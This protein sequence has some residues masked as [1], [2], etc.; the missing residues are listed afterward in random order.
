MFPGANRSGFIRWSIAVGPRELYVS[1]VSSDR[2]GVPCVFNAPAVIA[3]GQLPGD[4]MPPSISAPSSVFPRLPAA[5]TVTM[6]TRHARSIAW[7]TGSSRHDCCTGAPSDKLITLI[8]NRWRFAITQ[9]IP[10]TRSLTCPEPFAPSTFTLTMVEPGATPRV[11][12]RASDPAA[13]MLPATGVPWPHSSR[14]LPLGSIMSAIAVTWPRSSGTIVTPE[15]ST[16]TPTPLP[17]TP[18]PAGPKSPVQAWS[19]PIATS[20]TAICPWMT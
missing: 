6:F 14:P 4:V 1:S 17:E 16:A 2:Y 18:V 15:S 8:P 11:S 13:A 20:V 12:F 7:H 5:V 10:S 9:S 3:Y 19:A